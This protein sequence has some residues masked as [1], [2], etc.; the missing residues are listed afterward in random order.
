MTGSRYLLRNGYVIDT[1][2]EPHA[3]AGTDVLINDG[4]IVAVGSDLSAEGATIIDATDHIV[5]PG[6]VDTHRHLWE[7][8]A[9]AGAVDMELGDYLGVLLGQYGS[10]VRPQ[11]VH[12][13][14]LVGALEALDSGVT[15]LID[16]SHALSTPEHA[17][18][19]LDALADAGLR[20]VFAYGFPVGAEGD[21]AD[22]RR[23]RTGRLTDDDALITMA[24]APLGP[25]FAPIEQS[26]IDW[27]LAEDLGLPLS[28]HVSAGPVATQPISALRDNGLLR[29]NTLYV[30]GNSLDDGELKLI[31]ESGG[32]ASVAPGVE[33]QTRIGAPAASRMRR[34]GVTTGLG[35]D[36]VASLPGD[37]FSLM[38]AT[39]IASQIADEQ[40]LTVGEVLKM[41]TLDGAAAL[42]LGDRIGSLRPGKQADV[43]MLRVTDL[44]MLGAERDPIAAVVTAAQPSNVDTVFIAGRLVKSA[45]L[46]AFGDLAPVVEAMRTTTAALSS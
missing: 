7:S 21:H 23:I 42:G 41:A 18:A 44:N 35:V 15:T 45:G 16:Y 2:P 39:L 6:F 9:R 26:A 29:P 25:S 3:R 36:S 32:T 12:T 5:L 4:R 22:V 14:T 19:A 38:R 34:A 27:R 1:E 40:A 17:D 24:L 20:S 37:M 28:I 30:H 46:L 31:A 11:D 10:Q 13:A 33:A 8:V 43:T